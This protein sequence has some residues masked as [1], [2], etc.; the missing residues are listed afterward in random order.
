MAFYDISYGGSSPHL[1]DNLHTVGNWDQ[2]DAVQSAAIAKAALIA[3]Q[4][5]SNQPSSDEQK[6]NYL[7]GL[8][9]QFSN[10]PKIP[11]ISTSSEIGTNPSKI[12]GMEGEKLQLPL[13]T[14]GIHQFSRPSMDVDTLNKNN[15][16]NMLYAV[17][18]DKANMLYKNATGKSYDAALKERENQKKFVLKTVQDRIA[19]NSLRQGVTG[20]WEEL[21]D[22]PDNSPTAQAGA[23]KKQWVPASYQTIDLVKRAGGPEGVGVSSFKN[24]SLPEMDKALAGA[25]ISDPNAR[26]AWLINNGLVKSQQPVLNQNKQAQ[27]AV[28]SGLRQGLLPWIAQRFNQAT[29]PNLQ[30]QQDEQLATQQ[31]QQATGQVGNAALN[32]LRALLLGGQM[33]S[34]NPAP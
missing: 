1:Q 23:T 32:N 8:I 12:L 28:D 2:Q 14:S 4:L 13:D 25:G 33:Q 3:H 16:W 22:A 24:L 9:A 34:L 17:A 10:Q 27:P 31:L 26:K 5:P 21:M 11:Y 20:D 6:R 18:P 7:A 15:S 19:S 30:G 29:A